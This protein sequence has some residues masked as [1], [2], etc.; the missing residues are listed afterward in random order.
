MVCYRWGMMGRVGESGGC[1]G[2]GRCAY[3]EGDGE[4]V[5]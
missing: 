4:A 1:D 3:S 5:V 2:L